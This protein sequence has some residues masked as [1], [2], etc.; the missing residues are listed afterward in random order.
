METCAGTVM[1]YCAAGMNDTLD[2]ADY[3]FTM[4]VANATFGGRCT[5][6]L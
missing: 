5:N 6:S 3:A 2:C 1:S 4:C